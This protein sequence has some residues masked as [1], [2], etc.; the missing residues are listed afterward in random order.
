[1]ALE[2]ISAEDALKVGRLSRQKGYPSRGRDD[3]RLR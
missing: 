1:M 2:I 3:D